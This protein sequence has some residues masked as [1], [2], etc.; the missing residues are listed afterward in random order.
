MTNSYYFASW[1]GNNLAIDMFEANS[2][3]PTYPL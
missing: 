3:R 1:L 2:A